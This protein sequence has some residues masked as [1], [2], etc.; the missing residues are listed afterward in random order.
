MFAQTTTTKTYTF[1]DNVPLTTDWDVATDV[2]T[3]GTAKCE[4]SQNIGGSFSTKNGNYLGLAYINKSGIEINITST[5]EF[6]NITSF[7]MDVVSGDNGK[8][9]FAAYIVDASGNI[10]ET[11]FAPTG[12]KDGFATGGTNKWGN[13]TVS[14]SNKTGYIKIATVASSSGKYAAIDNIAITYSAGPSTDATLK[15]L[16]YNGTDVPNFSAA[17]T[18]YDVELP[19]GTTAVPTVTAEKNDTKASDP[20]ITQATAL[21]GA[22]TVVVT[23]EDG[24]TTKTY[25]INFTVASSAPKVLTATWDNIAGTAVIDQI[26]KTI[27]GKVAQGTGLTAITPNFTGNNISSWSPQGAQDFTNSVNYTFTNSS[28]SETTIYAVTITE[29]P[30]VHP[31]DVTLDQSSLNL[32]IGG[33]AKLNATVA[34]PDAT[35]PSV[36]W[37]TSDASVATVNDGTVVGI[38]AGSATITVKTVD[39]QK[40]ATCSVTVTAG[41]PVPATTLTLHEPGVYE[42]KTKE[43]GYG[44]KLIAFNGREYEVYFVGRDG[45]SKAGLFTKSGTQIGTGTSDKSLNADWLSATSADGLDGS[46]RTGNDE[47]SNATGKGNLKMKNGDEM[48]IHIKGYDQFTLWGKDNNTDPSKGKYFYVYIDDVEQPVQNLNSSDG[49]SIRRYNITTGEHVIKVTS[50]LDGVC[51]PYGFSLRVAQVP[52]T[53]ILK[54]ND[55]TQIVMQGEAM[56]PVTYYTKYN[57][58]GETRLI[59]NGAE[60]SGISLEKHGSSDLGDTLVLSGMAKC[61]VGVYNYIIRT[62]YN[63]TIAGGM[64]G[65][66]E[67]QSD[68]KAMTTTAADGYE[69]MNIDDIKFTYHA[70][71]ADSITLTWENNNAPTGITGSGTNGIYTISGVPTSAGTFI[72]TVSV[73]GGNS[74]SDTILIKK[75]DLGNN[76]ILY[77]Y[78]NALAYNRDGVY[79]YL[80][81]N[82]H[83]LIAM[84]TL[85]SGKRTAE[86]Y[87]PYKW[88]LISED[89]D[90]NNPEVIELIRNGSDKPILNLKGFTYAKGEDRLGWGDPNNGAVDST[91]KQDAGSYIIMERSDHP[92][93]S[94]LAPADGKKVKI[95]DNYEKNGVMPITI[96]NMPSYLASTCLAT[97]PTR[98]E[99]YYEE[100]PLQTAIHEISAAQHGGGKYICLPLARQV[101]LSADGK[102][103]LNNIINYLLSPT[104]ASVKAPT[105]QITSFTVE[106]IPAVINE[107]DKTIKLELTVDKF[108]ELDSLRSTKPVITL[109][110]SK[111]SHVSPASGEEVSMQ[112][113]IF[114]GKTYEV[115]DYVNRVVYEFK[116]QLIN[117][118]GIEEVYEAGQWVNIFDIY[119][120]KVATTNED[121]YTMDLPR[122]MY[123]VV[124]ESGN[125]LKIM[126]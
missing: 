70:L 116:I 20:V 4:I 55:S 100:G 29:V 59:W 92:I 64:P 40:T 58:F 50:K 38:A 1:D 2:P 108:K 39:G 97:A 33:T 49:G 101:T 56:R 82:S 51:K 63:G 103:L 52:K 36:T 66:F 105:L 11:L 118:Q 25:T 76:P 45:N 48:L 109:A 104:P 113:S 23:A 14:V 5:A 85:Q 115:T 16:K 26:N 80:T 123:I 117:P 90:A 12:A 87:A 71:S 86:Q 114:M 27:T 47:F 91:K 17:T 60:A 18:S 30:L 32:Q 65:K 79:Q 24:T 75:L 22:A 107:E 54:G 8:P 93:F 83:N 42:G 44:E 84:K 41:P 46:G 13:K 19:A 119:G 21:P 94:N 121:I 10:V 31:T 81:S 120:R 3:G 28:T 73:S 43:G 15:S 88:I 125:T 53:S 112:Y 34:P 67:V 62:Y 77:L 111:Y 106:G 57:S 102:K 9:T 74:I 78:K 72:Y 7:S 68:I 110:D 124:T 99:E 122:G 61:P 98:G 69:G 35:D 37:S 96:N 95:L 126:R 89:A 6:N